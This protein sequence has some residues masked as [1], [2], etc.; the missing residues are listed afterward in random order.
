MLHHA[1]F[2]FE[3][4]H[5]KTEQEHLNLAWMPAGTVTHTGD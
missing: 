1:G 2:V 5:P 3:Q 4:Q